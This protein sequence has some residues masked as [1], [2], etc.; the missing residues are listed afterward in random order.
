M[1]L[2]EQRHAGG[3]RAGIPRLLN[4]DHLTVSEFERRYEVAQG[5]AELVEGIVVMSPPISS[6]HGEANSLLDRLLGH[7]AARTPCLAVGVIPS[8]RLDARNEYQPDVVVWV[9]S[10]RFCKTRTGDD[11]LLKGRPELVAEIALS[12]AAY[13]LH[14][15]KR[16]YQRSRVPEYLVW[17]VMDSKIQ[18]FTLKRGQYVPLS[19]SKE[20]IRSGIFPGLWLDRH[21]LVTAD[22][23]KAFQVLEQ[24]LKSAEHKAFARKLQQ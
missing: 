5:R 11:G 19:A 24:G 17:E 4:G 12:S 6:M 13:D 7:Y 9:K 10:G 20:V 18:W 2:T 1:N 8:L 22:E 15:K 21:A 16:V 23:P 14:E 3:K